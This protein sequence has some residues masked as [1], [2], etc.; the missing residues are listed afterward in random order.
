MKISLFGALL[1]VSCLALAN[2]NISKT[3]QIC[4]EQELD[5]WEQERGRLPT[6]D[7]ADLIIDMCVAKAFKKEQQNEAL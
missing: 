7:E 6:A 3:A 5:M 2:S 1:L 4:M